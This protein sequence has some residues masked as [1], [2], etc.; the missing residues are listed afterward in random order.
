MLPRSPEGRQ[1]P[2]DPWARQDVP[3][4]WVD[5]AE[6]IGLASRFR[7]W[8]AVDPTWE[9]RLARLYS[10]DVLSPCKMLVAPDLDVPS[11][12]GPKSGSLVRGELVERVL[13]ALEHGVP[14]LKI[15]GLRAVP[16]GQR[17]DSRGV[18]CLLL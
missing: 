13:Q 14:A 5:P 9:V 16:S 12:A 10:G 4:A 6:G 1:A 7:K 3:I 8:P 15:V 18:T 17:A 2:R 11:Y